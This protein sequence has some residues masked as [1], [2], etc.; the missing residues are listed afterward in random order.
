[1]N[2]QL[3]G[4]L[5][6]YNAQQNRQVYAA[7]AQL[8]QPELVADRGAFFGS[9]VGTLNHIYVADTIWLQRFAC[10]PARFDALQPLA[11][12]PRPEALD[13]EVTAELAE[14]DKLR[15]ALD[16]VVCR[17]VAALTP[18]DL[19]H[20]LAFE[21]MRGRPF[22]KSFPAL[23]LHFFNHQTH[24]RGQVG[25]LLMQRDIDVGVTDLLD[26]IPALSR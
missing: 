26:S 9:I 10:H 14:L 25:T 18:E 4:L 23:L 22:C 19:N 7:A 12:R 15:R 3:F 6:D 13:L 8:C 16:D 2:T 20:N 5:A 21:D 1:M 11:N 17:F 24:H